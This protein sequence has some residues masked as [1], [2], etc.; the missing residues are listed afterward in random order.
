MINIAKAYYASKISDN[1]AKTP[2]GYLICFNVP[3][4]RTGWQEYLPHE[5]GLEGG[6]PLQLYRSEEEVF[7]PAAIASFEGKPVTS[8]HPPEWLSPSNINA[9]MRG[10]ATN[11]RRGSDAE[12]DLLLAD[13]I[14]YDPI[15]AAEIGAGK[16]DVSSGYDFHCVPIAG[17]QEGK[18]E[19]KTIRGN[20]IAIVR[21][22]RAGK[23]V[24]VKDE[25]PKQENERRNKM[26]KID[27]NS[28]VGK[29]IRALSATDAEPE[30]L[31]EATKLLNA[32]GRDAAPAPA[33][34]AADPAVKDPQMHS[35]KKEEE[36][37]AQLL[38]A[39]KAL[40]ADVAELKTGKPAAPAADALSQ[41]EQEMTNGKPDPVTDE[42][43]VTIDPNQI[44]DNAPVASP[45]DR[46]KN[47]I[48]GADSKAAVLA[49]IKV[50]KP[51]VAA[52]KDPAERK[53]ASDAL[54]KTF[55]EQLQVEP[56]KDDPYK[57]LVDP[58]KTK[59]A[60]DTKP[61]DRELGEYLKKT[62]NP[63][64]KEKK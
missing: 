17:E 38:A 52:I 53:K 49:A 22:G 20:H 16:R 54:A 1:Q 50:V 29:I 42:E 62:Y 35:E 23:R 56:A 28:L 26:P 48:S 5:L 24:A 46:P 44:E 61:D 57:S 2:E 51:V 34:P 8:E 63:H 31:A 11:V 27:K 37:F 60:Q 18:Y 4:A 45:E 47:P 33:A 40:Q 15:L 32:E 36:L 12:N 25:K 55:R 39:V 13:F 41:L 64:F 59:T 9:Y 43:A 7:H 10:V 6:E 58:K 14:V 19:Q 3:I 21:A 30:E